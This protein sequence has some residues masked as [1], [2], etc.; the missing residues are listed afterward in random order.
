M[1]IASAVGLYILV[2]IFSSG[3]ESSAR[4]KILILAI[5]S[6]GLQWGLVALFPTV[7]GLVIGVLLSLALI[8]TGL[9]LWCHIDRAPMI[10]IVGSYVVLCVALFVISAIL[11]P[12]S[13]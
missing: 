5:G 13:A 9:S 8:A 3:S 10:K 11:R 4:W 12:V 7:W 6:V 1:G 2:A